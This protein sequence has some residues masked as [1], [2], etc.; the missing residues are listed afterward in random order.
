M[1][2]TSLAKKI[3]NEDAELFV[4]AQNGD[5]DAQNYLVTKHYKLCHLIA[6]KYTNVYSHQEAESLCAYA[7]VKAVKTFK[8]DKGYTFAT[9]ATKCMANDILCDMRNN[10]KRKNDVSIYDHINALNDEKRTIGDMIHADFNIDENVTRYEQARAVGFALKELKRAV[11]MRDYNIFILYYGLNGGE[12]RSEQSIATEFNISRSYI[13][14]I[15]SKCKDIVR[16]FL[17]QN[18]FNKE[19]LLD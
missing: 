3:I 14:R 13:S 12:R 4:A 17:V 1:A 11:S 16:D 19:N 2:K 5:I 7:L 9:Y 18:N 8:I 6:S 15:V 10:K